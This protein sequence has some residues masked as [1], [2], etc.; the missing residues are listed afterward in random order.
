MQNH[1]IYGNKK[2][3]TLKQVVIYK[4]RNKTNY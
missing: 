3:T 1:I 4:T 2:E